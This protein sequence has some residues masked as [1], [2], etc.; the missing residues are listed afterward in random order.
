M[1]R[2]F[3]ATE[4]KLLERGKYNEDHRKNPGSSVVDDHSGMR[5]KPDQTW[6]TME[7][8]GTD[9]RGGRGNK[10]SPLTPE[11]VRILRKG[12]VYA[13]G[14]MQGIGEKTHVFTDGR[15]VARV[16]PGTFNFNAFYANQTTYQVE[17]GKNPTWFTIGPGQIYYLG[18]F[19]AKHE[20]A[21]KMWRPGEFSVQRVDKPGERELLQWLLTVSKGTGWETK[22]R[23]RAGSPVSTPGT[24]APNSNAK[25]R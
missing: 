8:A 19:H 20:R 16:K 4:S 3:R 12:K 11:Y 13:G 14:G 24:S 18:S 2:R 21:E 22:L 6:G 17:T 23:R 9:R 15:F 25:P 5:F 1:V 10:E 7:I